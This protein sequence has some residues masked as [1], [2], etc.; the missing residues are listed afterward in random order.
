MR[1]LEE[2]LIDEAFELVL[3]NKDDFLLMNLM[4]TVDNYFSELS[5]KTA[6]RLI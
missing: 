3:T 2:G 4:M 6:D 1:F 5:K